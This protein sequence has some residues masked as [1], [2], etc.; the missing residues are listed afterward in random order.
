M[1][2]RV[3]EFLGEHRLGGFYGGLAATLLIVLGQIQNEQFAIYIVALGIIFGYL[4]DWIIVER[5]IGFDFINKYRLFFV[6]AGAGLMIYLLRYI[7]DSQL[8]STVDSITMQTQSIFK[9]AAGKGFTGSLGLL[10]AFI[11]APLAIPGIGWIISLVFLIAAE[12]FLGV[13]FIK[14]TT[15]ITSNFT[16]VLI[17]GALVLVVFAIALGRRR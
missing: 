13:P 4:L 11:T 3:K 14:L 8:F 5:G 9:S 17:L 1:A 7:P 15:A 6:A 16:F 12:L 10:T 2:A